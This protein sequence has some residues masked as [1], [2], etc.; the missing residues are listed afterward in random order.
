MARRD[1]REYREYLREEQRSQPGCPAR[2]L[3]HEPWGR[4]TSVVSLKFV[5]IRPALHPS[6]TPTRL[7]RWGPRVWLRCSSLKYSRYSH[8]SR[9][10]IRA[11]R[12]PRCTTNFRDA[13]LADRMSDGVIL[14]T[15]LSQ[16]F[17]GR[18]IGAA[19]T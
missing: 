16:R 11:H 10:A 8:S 18:D 15:S 17:S 7:P 1:D 12:R 19:R 13:T 3:C 9:L 2:E 5:G 4:D 6:S 14:T